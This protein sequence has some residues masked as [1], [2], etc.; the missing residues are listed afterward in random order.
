[1]CA[2]EHS[3]DDGNA[4]LDGASCSHSAHGEGA[5][6]ECGDADANLST[7]SGSED[8]DSS[9][10]DGESNDED[11]T[12]MQALLLQLQ[13]DQDKDAADFV[14]SGKRARAH[15]DYRQLNAVLFGDVECYDGEGTDGDFQAS[16]KA[17]LSND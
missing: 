15:V 4:R 16:K 2:G 7:G 14:V 1:L 3:I 11:D 6:N 5:G 12:D 13:E 10:S 8:M 17:Y 9:D